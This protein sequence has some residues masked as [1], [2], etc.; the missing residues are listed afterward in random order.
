MDFERRHPRPTTRRPAAERRSGHQLSARWA[1]IAV[2]LCVA[3]SGSCA[4]SALDS[5]W[6]STSLVIEQLSAARGS[7]TT[8][9]T[10]VLQSDVV[11]SVPSTVGGQTVQTPTVFE[12]IAQVIMRLAFN[13]PGT[14]ANPASSPTSAN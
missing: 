5:G 2:A 4:N 12:D 11:T 3:A 9:F 13:D 10:N 1:A 7:D 6:A 8:T 14:P